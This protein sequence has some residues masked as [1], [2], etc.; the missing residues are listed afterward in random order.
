MIG[1]FDVFVSSSVDAS[2]FGCFDAFFFIRR[3]VDVWML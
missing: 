1:C 3:R 2:M